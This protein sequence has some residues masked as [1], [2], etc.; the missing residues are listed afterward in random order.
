MSCESDQV[1]DAFQRCHP[2]SRNRHPVGTDPSTFRNRSRLLHGRFA[3]HQARSQ[4]IVQSKLKQSRPSTKPLQL[5]CT[6]WA[7]HEHDFERAGTNVN[8][9]GCPPTTDTYAGCAVDSSAHETAW[10]RQTQASKSHSTG[11]TSR[12]NRKPTQL[13]TGGGREGLRARIGGRTYATMG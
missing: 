9:L 11:A 4:L 13:N 1:T 2:Y 7:C 8:S 5:P 12:L 6:R 10:V 3:K